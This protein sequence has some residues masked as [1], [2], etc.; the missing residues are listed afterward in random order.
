[1]EPSVWFYENLPIHLEPSSPVPVQQPIPHPFCSPLIQT[2][3]SQLHSPLMVI[4]Q[5]LS[6]DS[7]IHPISPMGWPGL[8]LCRRCWFHP[9]CFLCSISSGRMFQCREAKEALSTC[10]LSLPHTAVSCIFFIILLLK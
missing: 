2:A 6:Q 8:E 1:M 4:E 7:W 10:C 3:T 5:C 9:W